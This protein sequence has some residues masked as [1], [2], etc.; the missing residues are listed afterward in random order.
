MRK[1][2]LSPEDE[3]INYPSTEVV[4]LIV[5]GKYPTSTI[6]RSNSPVLQNE[7]TQGISQVLVLMGLATL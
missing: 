2:S 4:M 3:D 1:R 6:G 7:A 5:V